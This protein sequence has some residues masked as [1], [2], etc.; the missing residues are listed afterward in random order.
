MTFVHVE[1]AQSLPRRCIGALRLRERLWQTIGFLA[2]VAIV[3]VVTT[4]RPKFP[5][6][7]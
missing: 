4:I 7:W 5:L 2:V 3:F 6:V 1:G